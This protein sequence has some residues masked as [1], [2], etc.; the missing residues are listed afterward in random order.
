MVKLTNI[1]DHIFPE[2]KPFFKEHF[3][4]TAIFILEKYGTPEKISSIPD[5]DYETIRCISR[6]KFS[7][8]RLISLREL[9]LHTVG[10]SNPVFETQLCLPSPVSD[11]LQQPTLALHHLPLHPHGSPTTITHLPGTHNYPFLLPGNPSSEDPQTLDAFV[12]SHIFYFISA[13]LQLIYYDTYFIHC[14]D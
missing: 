11:L 13:V 10:E 6:G 2:Y 9:A 14:E 3:S 1:L 5:E 7:F 8:A 4:A 12:T